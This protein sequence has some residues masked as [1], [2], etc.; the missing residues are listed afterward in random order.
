MMLDFGVWQK[1]NEGIASITSTQITPNHYQRRETC[2]QLFG[3]E[4]SMFLVIFLS[5]HLLTSELVDCMREIS[6]LR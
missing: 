3:V 2:T 5:N 6:H 4:F 1:L